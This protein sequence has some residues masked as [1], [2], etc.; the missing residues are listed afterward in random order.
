MRKATWFPLAA[1]T[2]I[3]VVRV[4][5]A[6][7]PEVT[8]AVPPRL[9][10]WGTASIKVVV[11]NRSA[12]PIV[13]VAIAL[14]SDLGT[15][16]AWGSDVTCRNNVPGCSIEVRWAFT[17]QARRHGDVWELL[18]GQHESQ[19]ARPP[20]DLER[21][22][23]ERM[24]RIEP[25]A[26]GA[27]VELSSALVAKYEHGGRLTATMRYVIIDPRTM[28]LCTVGAPRTT[29]TFVPCR[30]V[31]QA[32]ADVYVAEPEFARA[33]QST[34]RA[35]GAFAVEHPTF[36]VDTARKR[37]NVP[38]GAYG[39]ER[40]TQRWILVDNAASRTLVVGA[41]GQLL[42]LPGDWLENLV[43]L[44]GR[45]ATDTSSAY[46][47]AADPAEVKPMVARVQAAHASIEPRRFKGHTD[48]LRFVVTFTRAEV[49]ALAAGLRALGYRIND[50]SI[51]K[52]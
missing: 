45:D 26:P 2:L 29:P 16:S 7:D 39:Y 36:D 4:A 40:A 6:A 31:S 28:P 43:A 13:P 50:G 47:R 51:I 5:S 10:T 30:S 11:H 49:P 32:T 46:W 23:T 27:T 25:I 12:K 1:M 14:D 21:E 34:V 41:S 52:K 17:Q 24:L 33:Q 37:A 8:V 38:S 48:P 42:D 19:R 18:L 20:S 15:L 44:D 9:P 3:S 35:E 22:A